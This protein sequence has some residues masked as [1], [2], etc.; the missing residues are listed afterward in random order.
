MLGEI[1]GKRR[2]GQQRIR[3]LDTITNPMN[4]EYEQT[5]GDSDG[6][7]SLVYYS[8]WDNKELDMT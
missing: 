8:P 7:G 2:R 1:E 5:L 3:W 4:N 6:Q